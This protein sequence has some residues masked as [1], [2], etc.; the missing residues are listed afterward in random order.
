M[1]LPAREGFF[2]AIHAENTPIRAGFIDILLIF[3]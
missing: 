2:V 3:W 1:A